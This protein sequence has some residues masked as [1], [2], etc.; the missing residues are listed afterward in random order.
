M[1]GSINKLFGQK[2]PKK[3]GPLIQ[4]PPSPSATSGQ[5]AQQNGMTF[6]KVFRWRL[7]DGHTEEPGSVEIVGSFTQWKPVPLKRDGV[8]D[9]WHATLHQIPGNKTH[10]YMFLVDG[11]P[12]YDKHCDGLAVPHG[13]HEERYAFA[14]DKGPR[15]FMLFGQ[16]K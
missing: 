5:S 7:P 10:H 3:G 4:E 8:L 6:S 15:V 16:T 9:A 1:F 2:S 14:T 12:S 13:P 11:K